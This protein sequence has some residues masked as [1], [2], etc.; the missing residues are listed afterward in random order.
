V[1][2]SIGLVVIFEVVESAF[3]PPVDGLSVCIATSVGETE[4]I[5]V[6]R[7]VIRFNNS[8]TETQT[9]EAVVVWLAV[10]FMVIS[11]GN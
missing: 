6:S 3:E 10:L 7:A 4:L 2:A 11:M 5:L 1:L 8:C 9:V